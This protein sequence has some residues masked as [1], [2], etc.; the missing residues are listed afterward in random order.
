M[1]SPRT[2]SVTLISCVTCPSPLSIAV[3]GW[4]EWAKAAFILS[5]PL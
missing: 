4:T 2:K 5:D 3:A 1:I